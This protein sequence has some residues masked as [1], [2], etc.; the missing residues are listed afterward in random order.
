MNAEEYLDREHFMNY[1]VVPIHG[2]SLV[3]FRSVA[4]TRTREACGDPM[5]ARCRRPDTADTGRVAGSGL[6]LGT[7]PRSCARETAIPLVIEPLNGSEG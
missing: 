7:P 4:H 1:V 2:T 5:S 3:P 6:V